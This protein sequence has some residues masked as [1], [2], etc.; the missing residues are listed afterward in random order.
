MRG[1]AHF[2]ILSDS[3][4]T[5]F[6]SAQNRD[7]VYQPVIQRAGGFSPIFRRPTFFNLLR[8][9]GVTGP[10]QKC[11]VHWRRVIGRERCPNRVASRFFIVGNNDLVTTDNLNI[12]QAFACALSTD[13]DVL[14]HA[15]QRILWKQIEDHTVTE[16][17]GSL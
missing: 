1:N 9:I 15:R 14:H 2:S 5:F 3:R 13:L 17:R 10:G 16:L 11:V 12:L 7:I 8:H 6:R 4:L